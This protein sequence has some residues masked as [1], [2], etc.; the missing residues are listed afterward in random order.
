MAEL[1]TRGGLDAQ[2]GTAAAPAAAGARGEVRMYAAL[3]PARPL[4]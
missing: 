3:P 1:V 2:C 4:R